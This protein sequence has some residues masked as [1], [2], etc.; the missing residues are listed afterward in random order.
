M[1]TETREWTEE[2]IRTRSYKGRSQFI[3]VIHAELLHHNSNINYNSIE[4]IAPQQLVL[5]AYNP[6]KAL[7]IW[8]FNFIVIDTAMEK[9][10][11]KLK[12]RE[13]QLKVLIELPWNGFRWMKLI[14]DDREREMN[15]SH[16]I[17]FSFFYVPRFALHKSFISVNG[18][19]YGK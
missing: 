11:K 3:S 15:K 19:V 14:P 16:K 1:A 6:I 13:N 2:W 17:N 10:T 9:R 12:F 4:V 18:N 7:T 5:W 8:Q